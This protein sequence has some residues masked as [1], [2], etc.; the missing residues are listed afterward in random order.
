M[1]S[2]LSFIPSALQVLRVQPAADHLQVEAGPR[3]GIAVCPACGS[4]SRR[5]HSN[6]VRKLHDLPSHGRSVMI[7]VAARRFRCLNAACVRQTFA[8]RLEDAVVLARRTKRLGNLQCYLGLALGGEAGTRLA[9]RIAAPVS[10]DTLLRMAAVTGSGASP[11]ATPRILAVDDWARLAKVLSAKPMEGQTRAGAAAIA[12]EP[13]W[14]TSSVI[15]LSI[16]WPI[17]KPIHWPLGFAN[18]PASRLWPATVPVPTPTASGK[19][20]RMPF[21]WPIVGTCCATLVTP[22]KPLSTAT[23][24]AFGWSANSSLKR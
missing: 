10:A 4:A 15:R 20:R 5:V 19:A 13:S 7:H 11:K 3:C 18:T 17:G 14:S 2:A 9:R 12:M 6:Y 21:K 16:C 22:S 24:P 23:M 1:P 8:E